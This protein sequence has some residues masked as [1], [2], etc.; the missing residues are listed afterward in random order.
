MGLGTGRGT[1]TNSE[2][3]EETDGVPRPGQRA[4]L[5]AHLE[6]F[7]ASNLH[8]LEMA[9]GAIPAAGRL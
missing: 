2:S 1:A 7:P 8:T 9:D 4:V 5:A 6:A 3:H